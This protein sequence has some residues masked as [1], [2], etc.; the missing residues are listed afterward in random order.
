[1]QRLQLL[2]EHPA[3]WCRVSWR[4]WQSRGCRFRYVGRNVSHRFRLK[5]RSN[6]EFR[7]KLRSNIEFRLKLRSNIEFRSSVEC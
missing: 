4:L 6:I 5:L 3:R 2:E 1:M 7:F